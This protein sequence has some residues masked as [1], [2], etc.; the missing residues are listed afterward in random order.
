VAQ[1]RT[2][3]AGAG[4]GGDQFL[5]FQD[6]DELSAHDLADA[7]AHMRQ[8]GRYRELLLMVDTCQAATLF[9][10]ITAPGVVAI[11]SARRGENSYAVRVG[12]SAGG[13]V[14]APRLTRTT[15]GGGASTTPTQQSASL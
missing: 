12:P 7:L 8:R 15:C 11:G 10:H 6:A 9:D 3:A 5:K 13:W 14:H 1:Y 4:H 2:N